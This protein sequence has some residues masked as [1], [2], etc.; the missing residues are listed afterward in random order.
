MKTK[1]VLEYLKT[2]YEDLPCYE[3]I[4]QNIKKALKESLEF[5]INEIESG[6]TIKSIIK[7]VKMGNFGLIKI[8]K[9]PTNADISVIAIK[10]SY[11]PQNELRYGWMTEVGLNMF[12]DAR[13]AIFDKDGLCTYESWYSDENK[14]YEVSGDKSTEY[15]ME[16]IKKTTPKYDEKGTMIGGPESSF[17]PFTNINERIG[18]T[19]VIHRHGRSPINGEYSQVGVKYNADGN[20]KEEYFLEEN[21]GKVYYSG[22]GWFGSLREVAQK[23]ENLIDKNIELNEWYGEPVIRADQIIEDLIADRENDER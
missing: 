3:Q 2:R 22:K 14:Y 21:N 18:K 5:Q 13:S 10:K 1:E 19:R 12:T 20:E 6:V 9:N 17:R 11:A 16:A 7:N 8:S 15:I 4:L 23:I